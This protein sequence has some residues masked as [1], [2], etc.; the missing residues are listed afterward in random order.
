[1]RTAATG[2][3]ALPSAIVLLKIIVFVALGGAVVDVLAGESPADHPGWRLTFH[4]EFDGDRLDRTKWNPYDPSGNG[5]NNEL[6]AYVPDAFEVKDGILRVVARQGDAVYAKKLRHYTSG[7][8]TTDR[9]FSQEY[10]LFEIRSRIPKGKGLWPT[11]WLLPEPYS[12]PP[13][14]DIL[15][16]VCHDTKTPIF[17]HHWKDSAG[18]HQQDGMKCPGDVDYSKDF[19][20][21]S[22]EWSPAE[23]R[24]R[25]DGV[26]MFHSQQMIPK[27]NMLVNLAVGGDMPKSPDEHTPFPSSFDVDWVRCYAKE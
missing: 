18:K 15:E 24:W 6:Q 8:M 25:V 20:V 19:H 21:F 12:W 16:F 14:I 5:R 17:T 10:G 22:C 23:I 1:M 7:M 26:E 11:F 4:D 9:K 2:R 3:I 27:G 13:E